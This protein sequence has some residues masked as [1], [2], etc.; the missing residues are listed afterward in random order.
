MPVDQLPERDAHR[1]FDVAG[2]L[3]VARDAVELGP[4]VVGPPDAGEPGGSAPADVRHLGNRLNIVDGGRA[5]VE[6]HIGRKGRLE[7]R[8]PLLAFEALKQRR[9]LAADIGPG[10]VMED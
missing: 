1:L 6:A 8:L 4:A 9:L 2:P 5:A 10:A 3:D 7:P